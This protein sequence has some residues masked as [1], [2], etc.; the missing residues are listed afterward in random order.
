MMLIVPKLCPDGLTTRDTK[1]LFKKETKEF[2]W[3]P[4]L[5]YGTCVLDGMRRKGI[6]LLALSREVKQRETYVG[7]M[8]N[9]EETHY[10][11]PQ[12]EDQEV[13]FLTANA[14]ETHY[15]SQQGEAQDVA[16]EVPFASKVQDDTTLITLLKTCAE[17]RD[18]YKGSKL[19]AGILKRGLPK[20]NIF[21][22]NTLVNMYAKC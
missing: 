2:L 22:G 4:C 12:G 14:E 16:A 9:V 15:K 17:Q 20:E 13:A 10:K 7:K 21:V 6:Q 19:H 1:R 5:Q 18:L 11:S 8:T 3:M